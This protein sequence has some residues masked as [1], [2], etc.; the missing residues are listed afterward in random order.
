MKVCTDSCLFGSLLPTENITT[1]LDIGTG[2]GL[3]SLMYAQLNKNAQIIALEIDE[4]AAQQAIENIGNTTFKNQITVINKDFNNFES[5]K[6]FDLIICNPPFYEKDL[7]STITNKNIA[8]HSTQLTMINVIE[9]TTQLLSNSGSLCI[10]IPFKR[11]NETSAIINRHNLYINTIYRIKQTNQHDYFRA[12]LL[13]QK[14]EG[15]KKNIEI[16]IKEHS[17]Y[18]MT[19]KALLKEFYL[20]F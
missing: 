13:I 15:V 16:T 2:T 1:V 12:I 18:T 6:P 20:N 7:K 3:L 8:H 5:T 19:F 9:K 17:E 14:K 10:L 4:L 11:L